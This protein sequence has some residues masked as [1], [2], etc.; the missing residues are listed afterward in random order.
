MVHPCLDG[1]RPERRATFLVEHGRF[2]FHQ[3]GLTF[4]Q[5]Q[6]DAAPA[7]VVGVLPVRLALVVETEDRR[8]RAAAGHSPQ[9]AQS[10]G[11]VVE[12]VGGQALRRRDGMDGEGHLGDDAERALRA[13][14][15]PQ[16]V[17]PGRARRLRGDPNDRAVGQHHFEPAHHVLDLPV[18]RRPLAGGT[19]GDPS[20][21]GGDVDGLREVPGRVAALGE[22][23]FQHAAHH[24]GLHRD[25]RRVVVQ[26]DD[27][28]EAG[29]VEDH[30]AGHRHGATTH[31]GARAR[32]CHGHALSGAHR[33]ERG[34]LR[35]VDRAR[36]RGGGGRHPPLT[37]PHL[38]DGPPVGAVG[39]S[40]LR[41]GDHRL[42]GGAGILGK[43][44]H[45]AGRR[46]DGGHADAATVAPGAPGAPSD[47]RRRST[48]AR[49][50]DN[51]ASCQA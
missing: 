29:E 26:A 34:H 7:H 47:S 42:D 50:S 31:A 18:A 44:K 37:G 1:C 45:G 16:H 32:G 22:P 30:A 41:Q 39:G 12:A 19:T 43:V 28:V 24:A 5:R 38:G 9:G 48:R 8:P 15:Q 17:G 13:A 11:E 4:R 20:A 35:G 21:D 33:Q 10:R 40:R 51:S 49:Y 3:P 25:Q 2:P 23:R 46:A 6:E 14:E 27:G 36:H